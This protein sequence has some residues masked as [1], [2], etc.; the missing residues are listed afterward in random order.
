MFLSEQLEL[1][2]SNVRSGGYWRS[3]RLWVCVCVS[4]S[5]FLI[6][7]EMPLSP[8]SG[9]VKE[10]VNYW[11]LLLRMKGRVLGKLRT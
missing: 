1:W 6:E 10:R 2:C 5:R 3:I 11:T 7:H 8:S 9:D 4:C